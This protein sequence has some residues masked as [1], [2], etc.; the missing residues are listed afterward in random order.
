MKKEKLITF[1][2]IIPITLF[3]LGIVSCKK[4]IDPSNKN[5]TIE[6]INGRMSFTSSKVLGQTINDLKNKSIDELSAWRAK[7]NFVS[8]LN[9]KA[10][11][12]SAL[13]EFNFPRVYASIINSNG[14][15]MVGDT[16]V[17]FNKG[18]KHMIPNKNEKLLASIKNN[19]SLSKIKYEAGARQ[20]NDPSSRSIKSKSIMG[21]GLPEGTIDARY[22]KQFY[23]DD[24]VNLRKIVFEIQNYVEGGPFGY[25]CL[26]FTRIKFEYKGDKWKPAGEPMEKRITNL[27]YGFY[28]KST[29][30]GSSLGQ[31]GTLTTP[32][33]TDGNNLEYL[34]AS[35][36]SAEPGAYA[37]VRGTY[38]A[39]VI[40][41]GHT[42]GFYDVS[43]AW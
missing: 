32:T 14:E 6:N 35:V 38:H 29:F 30:D 19:P 2:T 18:L 41:P 37:D 12:S 25:N 39:K 34:L 31:T 9:D 42:N 43:A 5:Q 23:L 36:I 28:Y 7:Y 20:L 22:Q 33:Q 10:N 3:I 4:S 21:V 40:Y 8:F 11:A 1:C 13:F 24:G 27:V 26:L 15:Y 16:I 17:W